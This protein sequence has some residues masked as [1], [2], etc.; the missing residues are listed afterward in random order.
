MHDV[1]FEFSKHVDYLI[2]LLKLQNLRNPFYSSVTFIY[3]LK[4]SESDRFSD[5]FRGYINV[6]LE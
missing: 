2:R 4:T 3:P 6:T 1:L 5:V